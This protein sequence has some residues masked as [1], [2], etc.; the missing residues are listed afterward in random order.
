MA[1]KTLFQPRMA[2]SDDAP[3]APSGGIAAGGSAEHQAPPVLHLNG[4]HQSAWL[5]AQSGRQAHHASMWSCI[6]S[7][8]K[9]IAAGTGR[10]K[11]RPHEAHGDA[12]LPQDGHERRET[13]AARRQ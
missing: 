5:E 4:P 10:A 6:A 13:S 8:A 2:T 1:M 12:A 3:R 11:V 9:T 7:E